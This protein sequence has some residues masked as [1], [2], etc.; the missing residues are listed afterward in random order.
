M[1]EE[2][3]K[4]IAVVLGGEGKDNP[5]SSSPPSSSAVRWLFVGGVVVYPCATICFNN[6]E[7]RILGDGVVA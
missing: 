5:C 6:R 7:P 1:E 3:G 4:D 2:E